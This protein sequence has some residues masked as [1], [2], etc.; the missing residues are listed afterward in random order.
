MQ[1]LCKW[2]YLHSFTIKLDHRHPMFD[3]DDLTKAELSVDN[4]NNKE[5][6]HNKAR[7]HQRPCFW[8]T[9]RIALQQQQP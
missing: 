1:T 9:I 8:A 7:S 2:N 4:K 3:T 6:G 5:D